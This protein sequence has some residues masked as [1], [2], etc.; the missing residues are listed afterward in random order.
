MRTVCFI[1]LA[2]VAITPAGARAAV[3]EENFTLHSAADLAALCGAAA[4]DR[5]YTAAR[6]FCEGFFEGVYRTV[7][8]E[9]AAGGLKTFCL[10]SPPPSRDQAVS[11]YVAYAAQKTTSG[12]GPAEDSVLEYLQH[13]YPCGGK[14]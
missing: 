11:G 9:E 4:D 14:K 5:Y 10:P 6:N 2:G 13:Q 8:N 1:L 12:T 7:L 3:S